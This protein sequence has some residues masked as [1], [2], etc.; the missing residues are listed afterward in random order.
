MDLS[1]SPEEEAFR[2][3]VQKFLTKIC[4][5]DGAARLPSAGMTKLDF[6]RD[7]QR[8]LYENGFLGM[9][10]PKEYGG[11][12][13]SQIE[14]AIF[15]EEAARVRAPG[16]DQRIGLDLAGPTIMAHG[17]EEQK[18]RFLPKILIVRRD[19]VPGLLRTQRRL[20]P[21]LAAHPRRTRGRRVHRQRP[22]VLDHDGACRGLVHP[23][24]P[25]RSRRAQASRNQLPAGRYEDP[26]RHGQAVAPDDRRARS[27]T[28]YSSTTSAC[29]APICSGELNER[30]AR[31]RDHADE[32]TGNL[33]VRECDALSHHLR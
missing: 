24:G 17:T 4:R 6:L 16:A 14:L 30:M 21:R 29:R 8:R 2:A 23:D 18:K 7:W 10:W 26:G 13:A 22:E 1:F 33:R 15:N 12:G 5:P 31:R 19:L 20:G 3:R 9:A 32:R 27:S 11:Q 28:R 25:H